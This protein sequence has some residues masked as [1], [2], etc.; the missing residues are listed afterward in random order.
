MPDRDL[1]VSVLLRPVSAD[2]R[3][4]PPV[5]L[6]IAEVSDMELVSLILP[7]SLP[8]PAVPAFRSRELLHPATSAT[9][10][11]QADACEVHFM[12]YTSPM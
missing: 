11:R 6:R 7:V 4:M 9:A 3:L 1:A 5:S 10:T 8:P 12:S 2:I